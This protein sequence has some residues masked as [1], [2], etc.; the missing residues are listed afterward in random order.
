MMESPPLK[1]RHLKVSYMKSESRSGEPAGLRPQLSPKP[2]VRLLG[3]W[4][5]EAGFAIGSDIRVE[6]SA[7]RLVLEVVD[8]ANTQGW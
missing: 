4:L 7:G 1:P 5:D 8:P 3:R 6:V 2:Y